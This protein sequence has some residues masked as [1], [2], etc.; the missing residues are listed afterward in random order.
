MPRNEIDVQGRRYVL[1]A[2]PDRIDH[3]DRPYRPNLISL[4]ERWP[5]RR[6]I[7][8]A[9]PYFAASVEDQGSEG[10]CTGFGLAAAINF[11]LWRDQVLRLPRSDRGL[12][13]I[14]L[15]QVTSPHVSPYQLY[16]LARIYDEWEGEDYEGS[17]CHGAVKEF[18]KHGVCRR[19]LWTTKVAPTGRDRDLWQADA[20]SR[21]LGA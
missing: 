13:A 18:H 16:H 19:E 5:T 4:P 15:D 3:R 11:V 10:A 17:C 20:A 8:L 7:D 1:D 14:D 12:L 2:R 6:D 21:P 9:L